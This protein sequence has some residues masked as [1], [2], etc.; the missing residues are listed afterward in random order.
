MGK[1]QTRVTRAAWL[2]QP[3]EFNIVKVITF[4]NKW[5]RGCH[6]FDQKIHLKG[7]KQTKICWKVL[8]DLYST[9]VNYMLPGTCLNVQLLSIS[10]TERIYMFPQ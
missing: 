10:T 5:T 8:L 9:E 2:V 4:Q 1:C 6:E 3:V 7:E